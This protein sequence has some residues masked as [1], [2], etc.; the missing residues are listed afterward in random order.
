MVSKMIITCT[1]CNKQ[2]QGPVTLAGKKIKCKVCGT[3]FTVP[4]T[5]AAQQS[6]AQLRSGRPK[7]EPVMDVE[8]AEDEDETIPVQA[9]S[10]SPRPHTP[11]GRGRGEGDDDEEGPANPYGITD[12]K[13]SPRCPNCANDM[14]EGDVV[15][16]YCGYNIET[17]L[18]F[19]TVK[20]IEHTPGDRILWL[21]PGLACVLVDLFF[22]LYFL[23]H[24][25]LLPRLLFTSQEY[26]TW[27]KELAEKGRM[28]AVG[29]DGTPWYAFIFHP[30]IEIWIAVMFLFF[31]FLATRFAIRRLIYN[32]R[33]PEKFK[34]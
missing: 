24:H 12:V 7:A 6:S 15:C 3:V 32:P 30:G 31:G 20:T 1:G 17:R 19:Q 16:L 4:A 22:L 21:L 27:T 8:A 10:P 28:S 18:K 11:G 13:L 26:A 29:L 33:P 9:S 2:M 14:E 23:F 25:F 34:N 5:S